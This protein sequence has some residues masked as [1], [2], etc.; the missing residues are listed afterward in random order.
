M[1]ILRKLMEATLCP[2]E[3]PKAYGL[4]HILF[5]V[6]SIALM[7]TFCILMRKKNDK[8]FRIVMLVTG[9]L[10]IGAELYKHF[11]YALAYDK[12]YINDLGQ[13][14]FYNKDGGYEWDIF[15]FQLCSVPMYLAIAVGC[16][17]KGKLRDT[18]C[19]YMVSI[20]FLGGI[21]AYVE[22]SGILHND[23]FCLLHSSIWHG[24]LIF[25]ALYI[26]FTKNACLRLRDYPRALIVFGGVIIVATILN[27]AFY[28][29][30]D[31]GFN[32][33]Y[34]SPFRD[35]PL[36]IVK[37]VTPIIRQYLGDILGRVV[38]GALYSV[39]VAAGGFV[40]YLANYY[41]IKLVNLISS[42][43]KKAN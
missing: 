7:L 14:I 10:L 31:E 21:M 42:K 18:I 5:M 39:A 11:Y 35:S 27:V 2:I 30:A 12:Y 6:I 29:K 4:Y 17:K 8:V 23:L 1:E 40:V 43:I 15:S 28:S 25:M 9:G 19:E 34:I 3:T 16:M 26:L 41:V 24:L 38:A 13:Q 33:C 20:G 36:I 32:M 22:P 37:D